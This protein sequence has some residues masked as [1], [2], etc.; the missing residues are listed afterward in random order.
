[1]LRHK[2]SLLSALVG[3]AVAALLACSTGQAVGQS[4]FRP[5]PPRPMVQPR[6]VQPKPV[7]PLTVCV[8]LPGADQPLTYEFQKNQM[9]KLTV[10]EVPLTASQVKIW[11]G[12]NTGKWNDN[13]D[14]PRALVIAPYHA[15]SLNTFTYIFSR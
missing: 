11:A 3:M 13:K 1:M 9:A 12:K 10:N 4:R 7:Q 2:T 5:F 6:P 15:G 14:Q 8:Q